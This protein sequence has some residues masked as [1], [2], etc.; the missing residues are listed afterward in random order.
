M[1]IIK[2][3]FTRWTRKIFYKTN[4]SNYQKIFNK[5]Y[6]QNIWNNSDAS[7]PLSGPG[8]SIENTQEIRNEIENFVYSKGVNKII[9][10]GCGDLTWTTHAKYFIDPNIDY[11]GVDVSDYMIKRNHEMFPNKKF[12]NLD[13]TKDNLPE[14][15]LFILRDVIFHLHTDNVISLFEN[16][17]G[18]FKYIAITSCLN[19][20]NNDEFDQWHFSPRN[21]H[22]KP[23]NIQQ[24]YSSRVEEKTFCREFYLI[25]H[26][27]FYQT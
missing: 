14:A 19:D 13:I 4:S 1:R 10:L 24:K 16:M 20:I 2:N 25:E 17:K 5:I 26:D 3:S 8:S 27:D 9:D 21:I 11:I 12:M 6:K 18:R 23:F 15:D 7:I 22:I